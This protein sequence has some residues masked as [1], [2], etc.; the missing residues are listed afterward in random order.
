MAMRWL[1]FIGLTATSVFASAETDYRVLMLGPWQCQS[2]VST[3]YGRTLAIGDVTLVDDGRLTGTGNLLL[4][5]PSLTTEIPMATE[6]NAQWQFEGNS[7]F[8]SEIDGNIVSPYPLLNG[9]ATHFK[10][11]ILASPS[12][13]LQLTRIGSKIM[14]LKASDGSEVQ[15]VR[16]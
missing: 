7:M 13:V 3:E 11:Q 4:S 14:V 2:Q 15:C 12:T 10:Q 16:G 5:H 1:L 6:A 8:I 9:I